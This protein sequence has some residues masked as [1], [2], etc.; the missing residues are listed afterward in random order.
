MLL[1]VLLLL[2]RCGQRE[3]GRRRGVAEPAVLGEAG[4]RAER[5]SA[6]VALDL[7][8]A[9]G[10]HPLVPAQVRELRVALEAHLAAE[11]L[12]GAVD[13]GVLLQP[14]ARGEGLAALRAGVGA[15]ADVVGAD[16]PLEVAGVGEDLVAVL[17]GEA[18]ELAVDH[19]VPQ[20]VGTP[21]EGLVAVL[22]LVLVRRVAVTLHHV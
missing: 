5:L 13:V 17:A 6:L 4:H 8:P 9:V 15:G 2:L 11:R 7:H 12:H 3:V 10:V 16:V 1:L 18:A 14:G 19:L 22:A 20:E 21:G